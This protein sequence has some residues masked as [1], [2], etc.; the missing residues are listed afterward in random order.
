MVSWTKF[1]SI[2]SKAFSCLTKYPYLFTENDEE[3]DYLWIKLLSE[4]ENNDQSMYKHKLANTCAN[5]N[6]KYGVFTKPTE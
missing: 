3:Y 2:L 6:N 5:V 4:N 1:K